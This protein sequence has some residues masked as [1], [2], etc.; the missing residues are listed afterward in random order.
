MSKKS[1]L[2]TFALAL[3]AIVLVSLFTGLPG[4]ISARASSLYDGKVDPQPVEEPLPPGVTLQPDLQVQ[5]LDLAWISPFPTGS[6]QQPGMGRLR[7]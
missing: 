5:G 3:A 6:H 1:I 7:S 2:V 4:Y